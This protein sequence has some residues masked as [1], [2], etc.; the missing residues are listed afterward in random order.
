MYSLCLYSVYL[1]LYIDH[2]YIYMYVQLSSSENCTYICIRPFTSPPPTP[3][4]TPTKACTP[5]PRSTSGCSKERPSSAPSSSSSPLRPPPPPPPPRRRPPP[6]RRMAGTGRVGWWCCRRSRWG[7]VMVSLFFGG[8]R[9]HETLSHGRTQ[10][11]G[12]GSNRH[13]N[14]RP[15]PTPKNNRWPSRCA[16]TCWSASGSGA[17]TR[18]ISCAASTGRLYVTCYTATSLLFF[19]AWILGCG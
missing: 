4:N 7:V 13:T 12:S 1:Y 2:E 8:G 3:H 18:R 16:R 6:P 5:T 17:S 11:R 15:N 19:M 9:P 10:A 14:P